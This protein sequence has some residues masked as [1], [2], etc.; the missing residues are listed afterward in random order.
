LPADRF[1]LKPLPVKPDLVGEGVGAETD[2]F[3]RCLAGF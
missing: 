2:G 1:C 3:S